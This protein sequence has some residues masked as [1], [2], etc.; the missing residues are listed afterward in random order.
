MKLGSRGH[1]DQEWTFPLGAT[2]AKLF[3][4]QASELETQWT[5]DNFLVWGGTRF[6]YEHRRDGVTRQLQLSP[7]AMGVSGRLS[8]LILRVMAMARGEIPDSPN[9][10]AY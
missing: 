6:D 1:L 10:S 3:F 8:G 5:P 4:E 9:W 7:T 2:D